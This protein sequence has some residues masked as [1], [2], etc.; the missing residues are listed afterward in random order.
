MF[1]CEAQIT[2][3]REVVPGTFLMHLDAPSIAGS[4]RPGQFVMIRAGSGLDP[5]L[6]RPFSICG[7]YGDR[8][9]CVLYKVVGR[10][11]ALLAEMGRGDRVHVLGPLGNGFSTGGASL[12]M[13]LVGGGMGVA[14]LFFLAQ[15]LSVMEDRPFR[16]L[17][18]F[19]GKGQ[20]LSG[21]D[22]LHLDVEAETATDDG[23]VGHK[24][25]VTDLLQAVL[26]EGREN[27]AAG[28]V[29]ACGPTAMLER[30]AGL[31]A[32]AGVSCQVSMEAAMACGLGAC[33]GCVV[34][35]AP[36]EHVPFL[37]VCTEGPVFPA[38]AVDWT[39]AGRHRASTREGLGDSKDKGRLDHE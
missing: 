15:A 33:L 16:L 12:P 20:V 25:P 32:A 9:I 7:L 10:G 38:G 24:G 34:H 21:S 29:C 22:L 36:Q 30:V 11:T 5:L 26:E 28:G 19:S 14:P 18:G 4:A 37:R 8:A 13:L 31:A 23:T 3:H 35:A 39:R 1:E 17:T 2:G 27:G 6:R